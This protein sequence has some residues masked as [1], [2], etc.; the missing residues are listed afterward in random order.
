M[1]G[2]DFGGAGGELVAIE[3]SRSGGG[4]LLFLRGV[5]GDRVDTGRLRFPG[6]TEDDQIK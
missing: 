2:G 3:S 1:A 5:V 4:G 6:E